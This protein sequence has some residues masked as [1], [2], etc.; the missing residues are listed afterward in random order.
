MPDQTMYKVN[1]FLPF[2]SLNLP[3]T[4]TNPD[5]T[6][7]PLRLED[8]PRDSDA[9]VGFMPMFGTYEAAVE[10]SQGRYGIDEITMAEP[11]VAPKPAYAT[12]SKP[13]PPAALPAAPPAVDNT[14]TVDPNDNRSRRRRR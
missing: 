1:V 8:P 12:I 2:S 5:Q 14:V 9:M 13:Q 11:K 10:F 3:W 7:E 4:R 6:Q